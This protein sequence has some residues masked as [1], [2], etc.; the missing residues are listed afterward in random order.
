MEHGYRFFVNVNIGNRVFMYFSLSVVRFPEIRCKRKARAL[1]NQPI[2]FDIFFFSQ[3]LE[4]RLLALWR[5]LSKF[6]HTH[7]NQSFNTFIFTIKT[8]EIAN[9]NSNSIT[10]IYISYF[11]CK[12]LYASVCQTDGACF[13]TDKP[14][15][16]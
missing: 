16:N 14:L 7:G 5:L 10:K 8:E 6:E 11:N 3:K 1:A 9:I 13:S 2:S 4:Y 15:F 12:I